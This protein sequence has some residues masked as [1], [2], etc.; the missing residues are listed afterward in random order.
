M[1][2]SNIL[3]LIFITTCSLA[4]AKKLKTTQQTTNFSQT[5]KEE[6]FDVQISKLSAKCRRTSGDWKQTEIDLNYCM[7]N[8][9]GLL[10][11][12]E[13]NFSQTCINCVMRNKQITCAC[14]E[15]N[16]RSWNLE[17][18]IAVNT[19]VRNDNGDLKC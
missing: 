8:I 19:F 11:H 9:D 18:I 12:E 15:A 16:G 3:F 5:C 2:T 1:R 10:T 17:T 6:R 4:N 7:G 14:Q 13:R